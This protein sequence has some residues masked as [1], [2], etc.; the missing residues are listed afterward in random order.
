MVLE[1]FMKLCVTAEFSG[2]FFLPPK[3][4]KMDP[5]WSKTEF[6]GKLVHQF[7]QN[8]ICNENLY[9]L[10]CFCKNL[11]FGKNLVP[12]IWAKMFSAN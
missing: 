8:L 6:F 7:L 2:K 1:T 5:K 9:Y 4:G 11:L 10:L 12:E 3:I